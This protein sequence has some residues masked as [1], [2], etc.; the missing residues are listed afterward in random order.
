MKGDLVYEPM[1]IEPKFVPYSQ[2]VLFIDPSGRG[3]DETAL[4]VASFAHGYVVI[5]E[6]LGIQGGYDTPTL[7]QICK[8]INQYDINLVRYESNYGDGMFGKILTPVVMQNCGAVSIEEFK[9]SG[10]K[11][12][13]IINTLEPIMSQHRLVMDTQVVKDKDNQ[14]QITRMQE[15]RGALKHDDRVDVLA[16]AVS[17][18]TE[19]LAVDPEREM[20]VRQEEDYKNKVK[21]WMSNKRSLGI[22]GDRISGA[23]LLNGKEPKENKF[24]KSILRRKR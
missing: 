13:R 21:E 19:A 2:T 8:L 14:L 4:C 23:I 15:K 18:W 6:L 5:H 1:H 17:Y 16:A 24:G 9:V 22:L 12:Q 10:Q 20:I 3:A 7:K 11:E